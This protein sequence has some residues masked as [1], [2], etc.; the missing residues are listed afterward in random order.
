MQAK[1]VCV[2]CVSGAHGDA[3]T[4]TR[5]LLEWNLNGS[6]ELNLQPLD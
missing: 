5:L 3:Q 6:F 2:A 1:C 4:Q